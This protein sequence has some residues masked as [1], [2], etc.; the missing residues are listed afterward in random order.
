MGERWLRDRKTRDLAAEV[1][2]W[3]AFATNFRHDPD[4]EFRGRSR[5]IRILERQGEH[6]EAERI[7]KAVIGD[8]VG[9]RFDISI[10]LDADEVLVA[11]DR[12]DWDGAREH[13]LRLLR[14][15]GQEKYGGHLFRDL[16]KPYIETCLS[17]GQIEK[18][19]EA[20]IKVDT[21]FVRSPLSVLESQIKDLKHRM[22]S[23][24]E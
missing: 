23:I 13:L 10:R 7:R 4:L 16:V 8:N 5:Q 2:F 17:A 21:G 12:G 20:L 3:N 15:Y 18:A 19:R 11:M 1:D 6:S 9:D 14:K 22:Q 24:T